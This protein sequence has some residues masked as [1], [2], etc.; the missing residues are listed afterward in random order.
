MNIGVI[1][2]GYV[3]LVQGVILAEFGMNV[4]CMDVIEEKIQKLR[5]GELPIY[6]PGLKEILNKNVEAKRLSFTTDIK[7]TT[8][9][10]DVIFIA[11]GTPSKEDGSADLQ[12]I[13]Q[14]AKDI[15]NN[16]NGY[17]VIVNKSTVPV[18]TGNLVE[19][20][21]REILN[22]R[23]V[24]FTFDVVSNPEFLREGKAVRD[25]LTPDRVVIGTKSEKAK[26]IMKSVYDVLYLNQ[27]PFVFTNMETAEMIKYASNAFLAVKI[28]YINEIAL[29]SEQVG[30]NVQE[31]AK[32]MGMDGRISPKF[33]H[34]GP[35]YGGS[36]FP[37]DT[38]A[39]A[40]IGRK[41]GEEMMVIEA[42]IKAN[43]KQK[44]KMVDKIIKTMGNEEGLQGKIIGILGLSF[45][46]ETDDM[47][48]APSIDIIEGL[49]MAG[50]KIQAYCPEG[51]KEAKWRLR[52]VEK[53]IKY[54]DDEYEA[55]KEADGIVIVTEWHQFR[56]MDLQRIKSNMRDNYFF[57]L[58]NIYTQRKNAI[59]DFNYIGV[60][61]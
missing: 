15:A 30:A 20:T 60:G 59:K 58:R 13:L 6:E 28:S 55:A 5:G 35:G 1:G 33:L 4:T 19:R 50:A 36:C 56:G 45:K 52:K 43:K 7:E 24:N 44:Q 47:R 42:A 61:N 32:A 27:T 39:I 16:M 11:V 23:E 3:G 29:L 12:Y 22:E 48:E 31:I 9:N 25:C 8:E 57:D 41:H 17:K 14:V 10:S 40:D 49:V 21:I 34:A 51:I 26:E 53:S 37:K 46:P 2:T 54:M 38:L 18:G